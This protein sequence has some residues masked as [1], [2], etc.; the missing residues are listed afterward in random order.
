MRHQM[1]VVVA[2]VLALMVA[3]VPPATP[4]MAA[5]LPQ[6]ATPTP[7]PEEERETEENGE[8]VEEELELVTATAYADLVRPGRVLMSARGNHWVYDS[9]PPLDG[10][11][12]EVNPLD[13]MLG[14]LLSCGL[15]IYEAVAIEN[16]IPLNHA[17]G[18]VTG[19]LDTRGVAGADVNP[20]VRA[21]HLTMNVEGP[22]AEE[23]A[24]MAAAASERCPIFS[25]LSLSAPITVTNVVY[26]QAQEP[27]TIA[28]DPLV[29]DATDEAELELAR[30]S[31]QARMVEYGRALVSARGNHW[32]YD[33]VPPIK[34]PNEEVNPLDALIGALPACGIMVYEAVARE[35]GIALDA[36]NATVEAD[37]DPRGVAGADVNPRIRAFRVTMNVDGPTMEEAAMMA[38][39]FSQRCPIFTTFIRSAPIEVTNVLIGSD[40]AAMDAAGEQ[41]ADANAAPTVTFTAVDNA[42]EGPDSIPG[43]LTRIEF[44]NADEKEHTLWLVKREEGKT[45]DDV[46]GVFM[47]L[48]SSDPDFPEWAV[49]H[50]GVAAGPGETRAYTIDLTPGDYSV[51]SFS[52]NADG[53]PE[54]FT[55]MSADLI[56]TEA[57]D[58]ETPPPSA[59]VRIEMIDYAFVVDGAPEAGSAIVELTNN[60]MEPHEAIVY[61]LDEDVSVQD[62]VEFMM[63]GENAE[64]APPYMIVGAMAPMSN[65]LTAW[66]EQEFESGDYGLF[67]FIP[68]TASVGMR[69]HELGMIAQLTV[70]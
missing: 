55:G 65:G 20:R 16:H 3:A 67:C 43:G 63:A 1:I 35:N 42:Y 21:F 6:D 8:A 22:S 9:V 60:G 45:F 25:T 44:V 23:A 32:I 15:Y 39:E 14:A 56:V 49:W 70:E 5:S 66:Y 7:V 50:G 34:G 28:G 33:S 31:A 40:T 27:V 24:M 53:V 30:P 17:S 51:Y 38:E 46:L 47:T 48:G 36:I 4:I 62:A 68:D 41:P 69:H 57:E 58:A 2:L 37:L 54:M 59:D 64:G 19:E 18:T 26:G 29:E 12:E 52:A 13:G 61:Q 11:N 10:P